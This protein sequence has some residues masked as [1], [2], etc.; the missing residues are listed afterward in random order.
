[1]MASTINSILIHK[2]DDVATAI[3]DLNKGEV[4]H[5]AKEGEIVKVAIIEHIP[6]YHKFAVRNI[7]RAERVR[8]FGEVIG[9][10]VEDIRQGSHVHLHNIVSPTSWR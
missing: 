7:R 9:M 5:Y 6:Q 2:T 10:A 3:A 4:A 8:K 1:V